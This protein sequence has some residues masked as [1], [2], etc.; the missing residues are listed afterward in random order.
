VW[1]AKD[2]IDRRFVR[3][4]RVLDAEGAPARGF[5]HAESSEREGAHATEGIALDALELERAL[6]RLEPARHPEL[7]TAGPWPPE[8]AA[9]LV[10]ALEAFPA[11]T[12]DPWLA[13]RV[14]AL[15]AASP[16]LA[17][18]GVPRRALALAAL[19]A[20]GCGG[21]PES[22]YQVFAGVGASLAA[23][24]V[25]FVGGRGVR[26]RELRAGVLLREDPAPSAPLVSAGLAAGDVLVL[27]KPLGTGVVL[28]ADRQGLVRGVWLEAALALL[29]RS[30]AAAARVARQHAG[31][32][33]STVG[34][35]GLAAPLVALLEAS[36]VSVQIDVTCLPAIDGALPLLARGLRS[37][38][39]AGN[40]SAT[41]V[42]R[43]EALR[44][45][46]RVELL[47]DP[48]PSGGLVFGVPAPDA[49][50]AV[51]ALRAAGDTRANAI[52]RV[53]ACGAAGPSLEVV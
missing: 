41:P 53:V 49:A 39:H 25:A 20:G 52:G 14:A 3:R 6:A 32:G 27:S 18:G 47:F 43:S 5:P 38:L 44:R 35:A 16:L 42:L 22:L 31:R 7:G 48:Q 34:A 50:L 21:I 2:W 40:A 8:D 45:D 28:A 29:L 26:G 37:A 36:G 23:L 51:A 1:R 11:F 24:N 30:N 33:A 13:G 9:A 15:A 19:P 17:R 46:A 12:D 4:F 10:A